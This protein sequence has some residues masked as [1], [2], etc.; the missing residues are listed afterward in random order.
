MTRIGS[1]CLKDEI[2]Y[3]E[4]ARCQRCGSPALQD[5]FWWCAEC[6][7][8]TGWIQ[9]RYGLS[10]LQIS[11]A[12]ECDPYINDFVRLLVPHAMFRR[13]ALLGIDIAAACTLQG[14]KKCGNCG[15]ELPLSDYYANR[16]RSGNRIPYSRCKQCCA[17]SDA[18]R[19]GR[20]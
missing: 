19:R 12:G 17:I 10:M 16:G 1:S 15:R 7:M 9:S 8:V 6:Y 11:R 5:E 14:L 2:V 4:C 20:L 3:S 18:K 13:E